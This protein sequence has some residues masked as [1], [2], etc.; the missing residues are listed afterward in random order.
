MNKE[1]Y[2]QLTKNIICPYCGC[3]YNEDDYDLEN[4]GEDC[5]CYN[6]E[7]EFDIIYTIEITYSTFKKE[8]V[9]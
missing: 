1:L 8:E 9:E 4:L 3:E 6:C 7:K 2:T 5:E